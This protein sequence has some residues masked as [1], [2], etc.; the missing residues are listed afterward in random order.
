MMR[1]VASVASAACV[2]PRSLS[3]APEASTPVWPAGG[4]CWAP[5]AGARGSEA[6]RPPP[7]SLATGGH[8]PRVHGAG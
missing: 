7:K 2:P 8:P 1:A 6:I 3:G 5:C 4:A